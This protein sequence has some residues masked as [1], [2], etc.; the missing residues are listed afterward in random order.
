[1]YAL[2]HLQTD[3]GTW[4][5]SVSFRRAG[6]EYRRSFADIKNGG[7][8]KARKAAM[9]WRERQLAKIKALTV[10]KFC[11]QQRSN[12]TSGVPGVHFLRPGRQPM[13]VWQARIKLDGKARHK[14]FSVLKHGYRKA[15]ELAVAARNELLADADDRLYLKSR[16]AKRLAPKTGK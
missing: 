6:K 8:A 13:G 4:R 11:Q 2:T 12:N 14:T 1:M 16:T 7:S 15:Y 3:I 10:V 9:E 5:W